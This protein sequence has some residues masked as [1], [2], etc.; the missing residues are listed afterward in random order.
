[1]T[2]F[3]AAAD[4]AKGIAWPRGATAANVET[5]STQGRR[6][7]QA[8]TLL[9]VLAEPDRAQPA[10]ANTLGVPTLTLRDAAEH[11]ATPGF[12]ARG[13]ALQPPRD[14]L[15]RDCLLERLFAAGTFAHLWGKAHRWHATR[16]ELRVGARVRAPP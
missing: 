7:V 13:Q 16:A 3:A 6:I 12:V 10:I 2:I 11:F 4:A 5:W 1:M 15:A 14:A 8:A 9:G